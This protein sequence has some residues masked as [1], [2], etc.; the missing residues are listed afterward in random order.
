[1]T[2]RELVDELFGIVTEIDK[3]G[4]EWLVSA[5]FLP[6][7]SAFNTALRGGDWSDAEYREAGIVNELQAARGLYDSFLL[8]P[9]QMAA[10]K[11]HE[12]WLI[13]R[14]DEK[15]AQLRGERR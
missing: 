7:Q 3:K 9:G 10:E 6:D 4:V 5:E 13:R 14:H 1:M 12:E 15:L 8:S 11:A 2:S